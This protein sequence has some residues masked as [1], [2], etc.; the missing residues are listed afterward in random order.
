MNFKKKIQVYRNLNKDCWS[1]RQSGS[2]VEHF[3]TILLMD[4]TYHVQKGGLQRARREKQRNVHAYVKGYMKM[5]DKRLRKVKGYRVSYNPFKKDFFY[6][7]DDKSEVE[8]SELLYFNEKG[9]VFEL[10]DDVDKVLKSNPKQR[11]GIV[12]WTYNW[13]FDEQKFDSFEE[14]WDFIHE[15]FPENEAVDFL[16][17]FFVLEVSEIKNIH[18]KTRL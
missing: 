16:D 8:Y 11:Y 1:A 17:E 13:L 3:D 5:G 14:A 4:C 7:V 10:L 2:T 18:K 9:F 6:Y 15:Q 12:D